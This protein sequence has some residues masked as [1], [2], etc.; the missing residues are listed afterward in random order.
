VLSNASQIRGIVIEV[1]SGDSIMV[2]P[3]GKAYTSED[4][5][6]KVSL[7]SIRAPRPGSERAGRPDEPYAIECK[8]QL[9]AMTIG[10]EVLVEI[11]YERDI[12]LQPGVNEKRSFGILSCGKHEDIGE[13][14]VSEGLATTQ[15]HRDED[16][17][18]SRYDELRAAEAV[19]KAAKKGVHKEGEYKGKPINDLT[20]PR[21]AK[22]YSGS[23]MRA[24]KV[25][26]TVDFVFNGALYK[27]FI[28]TENC[29]IR[30]SPNM[31]RCPQPSPT[32]GSK[33][34][35]R[36]GE[37]FGDQARCHSRLHV[38][39]R[40]VEIECSGVTNSGIITG[41]M[42]VGSGNGRRDYTIELLGAGLAT[43][44]QRKLEY[45]EVPQYLIDAQNAARQNK[46]GI[47]S[48]E[49][50]NA[51]SRKAPTT[52][53]KSQV[54]AMA[55]RVSEIRSGNHFF[56]HV[57]EDDASKI[58][59][60]S[61]KLFTQTNGTSGAPCD[62]KVG[63][64]VAALFDDGTGKSW[65]RA[66]IIEKHGP[67]KVSVVFIDHGN[68]ATVPA[69]THLRPLDMSL[70]TERIP[71]VA[72]EA[73]LALTLVRPLNTDEG[74]EAARLFQE[75][76]WG[77]DLIARVFSRDDSGKLA[78][79]LTVP[80]E[81]VSINSQLITEG[82]ARVAKKETVDN[83]ANR[84]SD[85]VSELLAELNEA[86]GAARTAR[87]GM[88]RYGDVGDDDPDEL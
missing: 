10:K 82:M 76:S 42:Y 79:V 29:Y 52:N 7:A 26:G 86:Q 23:L 48:L 36:A 27:I 72:Q 60:D 1:I 43:L 61:M 18:S 31:I 84:M 85:G 12:P 6:V 35:S 30:F 49:Q 51:E 15:R 57:A 45:G 87:A 68:V 20:D 38:L 67:S 21:K 62:V 33:Q 16:P 56:F 2:L 39:Q 78:V 50:P 75:L 3:H 55:I 8:D 22:A 11:Q 32:P 5:L 63:K 44:D 19:A 4:E 28:P 37:P 40:Q 66:K 70:S 47:W 80:G 74:L 13:F 25:K 24:G 34:P 65:Y 41:A 53:E 81:E 54:S 46:A 73:V 14:L 64:F 59:D 83:L 9:R 58:M 77:K 88:W 17:K 69:S 71:P